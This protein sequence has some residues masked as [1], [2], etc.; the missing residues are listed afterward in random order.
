M[1]LPSKYI[2]N[3]W[4]RPVI[5]LVF[6]FIT[7]IILGEKFPYKPLFTWMTA[8]FG[9]IITA[10]AI[11]K[12]RNLRLILLILSALLGYVSILS[13]V[14]PSF[15]SNHIINFIDKTEKLT[16]I[17]KTIPYKRGDLF[18]FHMKIKYIG[19]NN[20]SA[21]GLLKVSGK[22]GCENLAVGDTISFKGRI[23]GIRNLQN[24]GG[25]DY[26]RHMAFKKIFVKTYVRKGT[27]EI[28]KKSQSHG[29]KKYLENFRENIGKIIKKSG[30]TNY[31][32]LKA[33]LAGDKH[34]IPDGTRDMFA[35]AGIAHILAISGLHLGIVATV[36]YFIFRWILSRFE[37][38]L[39]PGHIKKTAALLTIFPVAGYAVISGLSPSTQRALIM[40]I[41]FF[42]SFWVK[43]ET[44]LLNTLAWAAIIILVI[45]PPSLFSISFQLSFAA[46]LS[47]IL[48]MS[49]DQ[50]AHCK[51]PGILSKLIIFIKISFFAIAGTIP[52]TM[53]YFN[54]FSM[55]GLIA[56]L[57]FV[58][59]IGFIVIPIGLASVFVLLFSS[60]F[61]GWGINLCAHILDLILKLLPFFANLPLTWQTITPNMIEI[62]SYYITGFILLW[63][64]KSRSVI[65]KR[66]KT[67]LICALCMVFLIIIWDISYW[68]Y[69]RFLNPDLRVTI[70]DVGQG[71]SA[72]IEFPYGK[73]MLID[74]GGFY[75]NSVFD[76]G[77]R[78][79]A[80]FL[81]HKKIKTVGTL[82]LSH[83]DADHLNGLLYI[84]DNF[85]VKKVITNGIGKN[86][87]EYE[88]FVEITR[89]KG[90]KWPDFSNM[91]RK[92]I[93][94][95][96]LAEILYPPR[97][98]KEICIK[99]HPDHNNICIVVKISMGDVSFLFPGDMERKGEKKLCLLAG[100]K[101][102]TKFLIAPHH[103]S[104]TSS[105]KK[106]LDIVNPE[107]VLIS[108][109]WKNRFHCPHP[110]VLK[111]YEKKGFTVFRT[112]FNGA[113]QVSTDGNKIKIRTFGG[114]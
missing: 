58:P 109:G 8:G 45:Y 50:G 72:L 53:H 44:D 103:G 93:I 33:L 105:T 91:N 97:N 26:K 52:I 10:F 96:A 49:P 36:F 74:G 59:L 22:Y 37:A 107:Y 11:L 67:K 35:K 68:V 29:I 92:M 61:A 78:V 48:G 98:I 75:D 41:L 79:V 85:N 86:S 82:I 81:W 94:N 19:K 111:K 27:L 55:T 40:V 112:D 70:I 32:I 64:F 106:F 23:R 21:L 95:G 13:W 14:S 38:I 47:I 84:A 3:I 42:I 76:I 104:G 2:D 7:G 66:T 113:I 39:W 4:R 99:N 90:I 43:R 9:F 77:A 24:P 83:P 57:I 54:R 110:L 80:P 51:N 73:T 31:G 30:T 5:P 17:V 63:W 101:L 6:V 102:K 28:I 62:S 18:L 16:G 1:P 71:S 114:K 60:F 69:E 88:K 46:V 65:G 87:D 34:E 56:N 89:K 25:L 15:P 12:K 108:A 100:K 20:L